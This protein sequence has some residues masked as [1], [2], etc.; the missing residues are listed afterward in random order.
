MFQIDGVR[1]PDDY[2][3]NLKEAHIQY[4]LLKFS[5]VS[6]LILKFLF[7]GV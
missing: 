2:V 4:Y 3:T 1:V 5:S 6:D 7:K